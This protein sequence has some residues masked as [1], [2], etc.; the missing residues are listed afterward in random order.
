[1][2]FKIIIFI[3]INLVIL[4][5]SNSEVFD[6]IPSV[7]IIWKN[8]TT[9]VLGSISTAWNN[10][11]FYS[12]RGIPYAEPPTGTLR[13]KDPKTLIEMPK[14][15]D[16]RYD[17][18]DCPSIYATNSSENCLT[19][20]IYTKTLNHEANLP[21]LVLVHP[22][23]LYIGS[24]LS[25]FAGPKYLLSK[26]IVVVTFNYRLG[27]LGYLNLGTSDIPGNAGFK[28]QV[29]ALR[30]LQN[31]IKYFGGNSKDVTLIG[32]SAGALS[33][34][35]HLTSPLSA[36][37]FHKAILM[38]GSLPPQAT[39]PQSTQ[40][41]L[42][43]RQIKLL[44]CRATQLSTAESI[45]NCLN[46]FGGAEIA[47]TLRGMF[48][49][50]KDNPIYLWLPV[51]E[52]DFGQERFY[53][54]TLYEQLRTGKFHKIPILYGF[55]DGEFCTSAADIVKN[56]RL[57]Q[58]F[59]AEFEELAPHIFMYER[60]S[61]KDVI[62]AAIKSYYLKN[63]TEGAT[64]FFQLCNL[65]S[66]AIIRFGAV[67]LA[68][69]ASKYTNVYAY[70]FVYKG[71]YSNLNFQTNQSRVEHMD[72]FMY[73]FESELHKFNKQDKD[74]HLVNLYTNYLYDFIKSRNIFANPST[75]YPT[76]YTLISNQLEFKRGINFDE[77]DFWNEHFP[78]N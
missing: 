31:Y 16:A 34:S 35:L 36:E 32:Y 12:F 14:I 26:P 62:N 27:A 76:G 40:M 58:R 23:G 44:N 50:G 60:N 69:L 61:N 4:K 28:D 8:S 2:Y 54:D 7:T 74:A 45:L 77:Y 57:E 66:D 70:K 51:V 43:S 53:T 15:I 21:V 5:N 56:Q 71:E 24:G 78:L 41:E 52:A 73:L 55:T 25:S 38:S 17:G 75:A 33:I 48:V 29:L 1:M 64:N 6:D 42:A 49:F 63:S 19:I 20:N 65:F 68:K 10:D 11:T 30:W 18:H 47:A 9:T 37:L 3:L 46:K 59:Y 67:R 13:F 72:D 22:G 39:L